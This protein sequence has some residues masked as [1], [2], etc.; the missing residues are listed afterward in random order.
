MIGRRRSRSNL[1]KRT[2]LPTAAAA[3]MTSHPRRCVRTYS[4]HLRR[5]LDGRR[6][7]VPQH[8]VII[9]SVGPFCVLKSMFYRNEREIDDVSSDGFFILWSS[10]AVTDAAAARKWAGST[11]AIPRCYKIR[12]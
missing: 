9:Y 10:R 6:P 2:S 8:H 11:G 7:L 3:R 4:P 5:N 12:T 1:P